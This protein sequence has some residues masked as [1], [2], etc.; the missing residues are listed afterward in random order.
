MG[1]CTLRRVRSGVLVG[2]T[3]TLQTNLSHVGDPPEPIRRRRNL[4]QGIEI[5]LLRLFSRKT[6][7]RSMSKGTWCVVRFPYVYSYHLSCQSYSVSVLD[8]DVSARLKFRKWYGTFRRRSRHEVTKRMFNGKCNF[9]NSTDLRKH[10]VTDFLGL[11]QNTI[12]R[13][14][15][16][17]TTSTTIGNLIEALF[18]VS[19]VGDQTEYG[20]P[21]HDRFLTLLRLVLGLSS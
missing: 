19:N 1:T 17:I 9:E 8:L 20:K 7:L 21:L 13:S 5:R 16:I 3:L 18:R 11:G 6:G 4:V 15:Y 14:L 10:E 12:N 2:R